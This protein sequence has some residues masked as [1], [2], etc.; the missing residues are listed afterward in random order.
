MFE[1]ELSTLVSHDADLSKLNNDFLQAH[2][3]SAPHVQASLRAKCELLDPASKD[4]ASQDLIRTLALEGSTLE[5]ALRGLEL[6]RGWKADE[7]YVYTYI[8]AAH[9]RY[10]KA[11]AFQEGQ[12]K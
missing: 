8:A 9:E 2:H 5:D 3:E 11:T 6:L 1:S 7:K 12:A 10:P 4:N